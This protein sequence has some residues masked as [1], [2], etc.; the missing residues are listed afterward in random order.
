MGRARYDT[1]NTLHFRSMPPTPKRLPKSDRREQ[2]LDT[3]LAMV[4]EEGTDLLTLG[5][6]AERAGVTKPIA[7]THFGTRSGLLAAL[8]ARLDLVQFDALRKSLKDAPGRLEAIAK[9]IAS[10]YVDCYL[11]AGAELQAVTAA[12]KGDGAA[13]DAPVDKYVKL[14]AKALAPYAQTSGTQLLLRCVAINGAG[15]ALMGEMVAER[16]S[17]S[18]AVGALSAVIIALV[19][20][21]KT[22]YAR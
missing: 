12:L 5:R 7:Y 6:L 20:T 3:A 13:V 10:A 8:H 21:D 19:T 4:R 1:K 11:Q 17:A 15:E 22:G 16:V 18:T 9:V 2:L 14:Y